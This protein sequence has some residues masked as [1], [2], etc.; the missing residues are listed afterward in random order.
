MMK[1][2][3]LASAL[4]LASVSGAF[5]GKASAELSSSVKTQILQLVPDADLSN[6]TTSQYV[7]LELF[8]GNSANLRAGEDP[9]QRVKV[10]LAAG[11]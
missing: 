1:H 5:A 8:F 11:K 3:V 6:L 2:I 4:L 10:I 9:A 7:R